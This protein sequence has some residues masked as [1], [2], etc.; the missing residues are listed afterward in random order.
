MNKKVGRNDPCPCG[1]GKKFKRCHGWSTPR[2]AATSDAEIQAALEKLSQRAQAE[3][4]QRVEQ[5]GLGRPIIST[6]V[7]GVR[8]VAVGDKV[9]SSPRWKSFHDFLH[10]YVKSLIENQWA[11]EELKKPQEERHPL[12]VWYEMTVRHQNQYIREP[13]RIATAPMTGAGAAYLGLAYNLYLTAHN[14]EVQQTLLR[15]LMK[16][17]QFYGAYYE[18]YV[19]GLLIRAG[20]DI[21]FENEADVTTSHCELTATFRKTGKKFSVEAKM[22]GANKKSADIGNQLYAALKKRAEHTRVIFIEVN[23]PDNCDNAT[24][25]ANLIMALNSLRSR[26]ETL[27]IDGQP[28]PP[29]YVLVTNNPHSYSLNG[30]SQS[31]GLA[32][33]FKIPD[34]KVEAQFTSLREAIR[35]RKKHIEIQSLIKVLAR[36]QIPSTFDGDNPDLVFGEVVGRLTVGKFYALPDGKGG[37]VIGELTHGCVM[38]DKKSAFC[39]Y[40][41][42]NGQNIIG[43]DPMSDAEMAAY[44]RHPDTFFGVVKTGSRGGINDPLE[45]YDYCLEIYTNTPKERLLEMLGVRGLEFF[46]KLSQREL[47]ELFCEGLATKVFAMAQSH[48]PPPNPPAAAV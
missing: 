4:L 46:E 11:N 1:S 25:T 35:N 42:P 32:E 7:N 30:P 40:K 27:T 33:G 29:A 47:A 3:E 8:C 14:V 13:G 34:F 5:Q 20:F 26:E 15:R 48:R 44:R 38:E 17:D 43:Q 39:V 21:E 31:A 36:S 23:L 16:K 37:E 18:A 10:D 12:L 28:A 6:L 9:F 22:R 2:P 41:L 45:F 24:A 19:V